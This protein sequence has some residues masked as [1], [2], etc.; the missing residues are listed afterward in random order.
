MSKVFVHEHVIQQPWLIII[1][2]AKHETNFWDGS[3][4]SSMDL[5][6][7]KTSETD[8]NYKNMIILEF[9]EIVL[10]A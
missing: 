5:L 9:V 7:S 1:L 8:K 10:R 2:R 4:K 6:P 3:M